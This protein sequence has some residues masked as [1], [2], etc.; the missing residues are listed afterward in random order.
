[1]ERIRF[2]ARIYPRDGAE[3]TGG[4][5]SACCPA[6]NF[7]RPMRCPLFGVWLSAPRMTRGAD[8]RGSCT[9]KI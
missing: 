4:G 9:S 2:A 7:G 3:Y 1:M 5:A 6:V 8:Q